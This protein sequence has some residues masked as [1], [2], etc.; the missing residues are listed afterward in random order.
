L[1]A[2]FA[3]NGFTRTDSEPNDKKST[4]LNATQ[5]IASWDSAREVRDRAGVS[6]NHKAW[7]RA[8]AHGLRKA[9]ATRLA[10]LGAT[11]RMI[12]GLTGHRTLKEVEVYT[13]AAN[14]KLLADSA[15]Q[16]LINDQH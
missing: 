9:T 13:R 14:Q 3:L 4:G 1:R 8:I 12:Q 16:K 11:P 10:A 5:K 2:Q 7:I 6:P 15:M